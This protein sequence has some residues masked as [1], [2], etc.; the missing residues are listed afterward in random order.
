MISVV[1][2]TRKTNRKHYD[3]IRRSSGLKNK[4]EVIEI[5]N[6]GES[7]TNSYNRGLKESSYDI[8]VFCH[9]DIL[10]N[11]VGWGRKLINH[12]EKSDYGILG[13]A[14]TTNLS[15]NGR[16]WSDSSKMVGIVKHAHNGKTVESKYSTNF[17]SEIL[18]TVI[19][20]GLFFAVHKDR[21][22]ENFDENVEGF[23]FYEIDFCFRNKLSGVKI[24]VI[25]DVKI[26]HKSIGETN[27][28]W[29]ENRIAFSEKF[30]ENLPFNI[31][32]EINFKNKEIK[33]KSTPNISVII[34]T[35]SNLELLF[36]TI[37]SLYDMDNYENFEV[38]IAD[39]GSS[40][41]ELQE[42][43]NFIETLSIKS[44][45]LHIIK[46]IE[47]DYYNF[48]KINNDIV[49]NHVG[50][51][52]E[53]LLFC[54]NDIKLLNNAITQMV[55]TYNKNRKTVGTIGCRLHYGDNSIQHSGISM[56]L[57]NN[58]GAIGF[59]HK[60]L[61]SYHNY[62]LDDTKVF[63]NTAAF[64]LTNKNLFN[65]IGGFNEE[66]IECFEDVEYNIECL[67]KGYVN[68]IVGNAVAY[69]YESQTRKKTEGK[70][71]REIT[72]LKRR[73]LPKV[74]KNKE[75]WD[76]FE[77]ISRVNFTD[78][79]NKKIIEGRNKKIR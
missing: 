49:K 30:A 71:D 76:Y 42:I 58:Q 46:L 79:Y 74:L 41:E 77:N 7:L 4:I 5:V 37:K 68:I 24:G 22:K 6:N 78:F 40:N 33:L 61:K 2:C 35:K 38:L 31:T 56:S 39:T 28:K 14:G 53:L 25:F 8:V 32:P 67:I 63:G 57:V 9:D 27:D 51:G 12:F 13:V 29:E 34:P 73:L 64:M 11:K 47:Y 16:W 44:D 60:G 45:R 43:R 50:E 52:F 3:H 21:I 66:Y 72:D 48:A 18:E 59:T 20:D 23:H 75:T 10:F 36:Q 17:G 1:Y 70:V 19:V 26:T 15:E 65:E 54:N 55:N 69:H 62:Y